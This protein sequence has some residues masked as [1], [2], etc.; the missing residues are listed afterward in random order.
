ML[1]SGLSLPP[2]L[3]DNTHRHRELKQFTRIHTAHRHTADDMHTQHSAHTE[4]STPATIHTLTR[5]YINMH[6]AHRYTCLYTQHAGTD[7]HT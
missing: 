7:I 6:T 2:T 4:H 3:I 1:I 5:A